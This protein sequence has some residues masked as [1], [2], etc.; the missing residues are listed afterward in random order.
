M[1]IWNTLERILIWVGRTSLHKYP[2]IMHY[3]P[4]CA[5]VKF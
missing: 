1:T 5:A 2:C 4:I 3:L